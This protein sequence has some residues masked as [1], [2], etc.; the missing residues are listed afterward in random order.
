M[1]FEFIDYMC[2]LSPQIFFILTI[3]ILSN[4]YVLV[5]IF[6]IG[7]ILN[8]LLNKY[9]KKYIFRKKNETIFLTQTN[10]SEKHIDNMPSGHMQSNTFSLL[11]YFLMSK[12]KNFVISLLY[13]ILYTYTTYHCFHYKYHTLTDMIVGVM[14]GTIFCYLY[15]FIFRKGIAK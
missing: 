4:D 6:C 14:F 1:Y 12:N 9:L 13:I 3:F 5:I 15:F 11:F 7:F 10:D 8:I 2:K